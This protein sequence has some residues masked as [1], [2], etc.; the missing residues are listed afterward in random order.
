MDMAIYI[1]SILKSNPMVLWIWGFNS[2]KALPNNEGL[3][4]G[5]DGFKHK[6][7]V[8]IVYDEGKDLFEVILLD[9]QNN[10]LQR[11]KDV[12]IDCLIEIIDG[13]VDTD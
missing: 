3:I 9:S 12:Y 1:Y 4:F 7:W 13:A 5:V 6:G 8:K 2:P 10:V 11:F